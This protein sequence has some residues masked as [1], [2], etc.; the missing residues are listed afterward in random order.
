M[1][2]KIDNIRIYVPNLKK[3]V[4]YYESLGLSIKWKTEDSVGF[5]MEDAVSELVIQTKDK[6][7]E[8][9][10]KVLDV[11]YAIEKVKKSGGSV[12]VEPFDIPIGKCAVISDPWG[13]EMVI[14]DSSKGTFFTDKNANVIGNNKL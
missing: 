9:D 6:W 5:V 4:E 1:F 3:G 10:I 8:T 11:L 14:L 13:N 12:S 7:N 2:Q